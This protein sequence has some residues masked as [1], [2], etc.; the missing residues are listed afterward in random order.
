MARDDAAKVSRHQALL[1]LIE[2]RG[3]L[4]LTEASQELAV[5]EQTIRRDVLA[6]QTEGKVRK[7]HGGVTFA[8]VLDQ[9]TYMKRQMAQPIE[10]L[11]IAKRVADLIPDGASV[12]LD[13]GTTCEAIAEALLARRGLRVVTYSFRCAARLTDRDDITVAIPGGIVRHLDGAIVGP[14]DDGFIEQFSFDFAVVAVSGLNHR[15]HL[16]DDDAFEVSRVRAAMDKAGQTI[17][18]LTSDKFGITGLVD[19]ADFS[20]IDIA[21][22]NGPPSDELIDLAHKKEVVLLQA[23]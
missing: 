1:D 19:L 17:L 15:G 11:V 13:S 14:L 22:V 10:K 7:T 3:Y 18:A 4:S 6:L 12:F 16:G 23:D 2:A 20:E 21:V 8:G 9:G 5:S